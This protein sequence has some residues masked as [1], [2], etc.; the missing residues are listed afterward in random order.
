MHIQF[1]VLIQ[2]KN[3]FNLWF[4]DS[5]QVEVVGKESLLSS[6]DEDTSFRNQSVWSNG[7]EL[8]TPFPKL[9]FWTKCSSGSQFWVLELNR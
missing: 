2:V 9:V 8:V 7:A 3:I 5:K 4:V 6:I 1:S